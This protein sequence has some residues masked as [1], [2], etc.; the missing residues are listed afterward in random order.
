MKADERAAGLNDADMDAE[1]RT[2]RPRQRGVIV[3]EASTTVSAALKADSVPERALLGP[4]NMM[5]L[6]FPRPLLR[7]SPTS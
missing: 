7:K 3:F 2:T 1:R 6:R 5:F 4:R